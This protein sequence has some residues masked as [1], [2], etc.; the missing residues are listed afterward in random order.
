MKTSDITTL[1]VSQYSRGYKKEVIHLKLYP[2]R[3][4]SIIITCI[5]PQT[6]PIDYSHRAL[7]YEPHIGVSA[8]P[9]YD[10]VE[11]GQKY[12]HY[13]QS[14]GVTWWAVEASVRRNR[15]P[16]Y[17]RRAQQAPGPT[18]LLNRPTY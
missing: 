1:F 14:T 7:F 2:T 15:R 18:Y 12:L 6:S 10:H 9:M 3:P 17:A 5:E 11:V 16:A 13:G 8:I 4:N